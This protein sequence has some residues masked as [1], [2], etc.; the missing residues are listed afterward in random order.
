MNVTVFVP[1]QIK[2]KGDDK[3]AEVI[4]QLITI[5]KIIGISELDSE[6]SLNIDL[7]GDSEIVED[8]V[9]N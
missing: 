6:P 1:I 5:N 4:E 2:I 7:V 9:E 8:D 3:L